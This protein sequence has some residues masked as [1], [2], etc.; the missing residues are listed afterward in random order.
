M[1]EFCINGQCKRLIVTPEEFALYLLKL[2]PDWDF[3]WASLKLA[4]KLCLSEITLECS[5]LYFF[6]VS[7]S[8]SFSRSFTEVAAVF[9]VTVTV[10]TLFLFLTK[11]IYWKFNEKCAQSEHAYFIFV[12][13]MWLVFSYLAQLAFNW[14]S[15]IVWNYCSVF[16]AL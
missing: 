2:N 4:V 6:L 5:V 3:L 13:E 11:R 16:Y 12:M 7:H 8:F 1:T 14:T 10:I 9:H 15:Q